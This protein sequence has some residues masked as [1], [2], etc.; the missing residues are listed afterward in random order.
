MRKGMTAT[1]LILVLLFGYTVAESM[2]HGRM[3]RRGGTSEV[4]NLPGATVKNPQGED[5]GIINDI[6]T[7]PEGRAT[8]A[9]LI[10]MI[11]DDTQKRVAVPFDALSC[12]GQ[13]CVLNANRDALDSAP[14]FISE[15]DL[16]EPELAGDIYRYF[17]LQP[18]WIEEGVGE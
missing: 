8:F 17:G 10:Y 15:N 9:V 1:A 6:V 18:Y 12:E 7:G 4:S 14:V 2:A 16:A 13:T 3:S 11:S 5:L